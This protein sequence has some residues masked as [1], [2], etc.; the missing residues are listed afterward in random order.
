MNVFDLKIPEEK[1]EILDAA[2]EVV[3]QIH[4]H[5]YRGHL[6]DEEKHRLIITEWSNGKAK[7]EALVKATYKPGTDVYSLIDS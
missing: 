1:G 5:R 7:I 4:N 6:S 3:N 2:Q